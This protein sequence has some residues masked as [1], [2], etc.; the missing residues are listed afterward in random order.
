MVSLYVDDLFVR[1]CHKELIDKF[2]EE[3]NDAFEMTD[4][5]RMTFFLGMQVQQNQ[6]EIFVFQQKYGREILKRFNM[7][8]CKPAPT[9]MNQKEKFCK[10]DGAKKV[11]ERLYRRL[12][13]CLIYLS[14]TMSDIM[15][16]V[17]LLSRYMH[18]VSEIHSQAA[19]RILRY[20][21]GTI[22][23][24]I[25]FSHVKNFNLHGYADSDWDGCDDG[26]K[27]TS[28]YCFSFGSGIFSC[29]S[30]KREVIVQSTTEAKYV[31]VVTIV[32]QAIWIRKLMTNLHM[33]QTESTHV[34]V[35]N[36]VGIVITNNPVFHGKTKHF[37]IKFHVLR[38]TQKE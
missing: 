16:A 29:C 22:Y 7:E 6:N 38:D 14:V 33:E 23:Y 34:F 11:D 3:T 26:M 20:V 2:K 31:V 19:K 36:Q 8:E 9:P 13:G 5:G 37:K 27:S 30:T 17:N 28:G 18:C 32:N 25:R 10:E 15:H 4:L 24:G 35:D 12:I 1:G 21:K